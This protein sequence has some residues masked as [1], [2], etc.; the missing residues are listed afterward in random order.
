MINLY[1]HAGASEILETDR[2]A[3]QQHLGSPGAYHAR[4]MYPTSHKYSTDLRELHSYPDE[5]WP[6]MSLFVRI[7]VSLGSVS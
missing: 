6:E 3:G 2:W 5:Q 7:L 4:F 1:T